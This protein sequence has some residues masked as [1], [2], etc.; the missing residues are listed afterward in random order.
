MKTQNDIRRK[1]ENIKVEISSFFENEII[2]NQRQINK[3][4]NEIDISNFFENEIIRNQRK[5]KKLQ[6]NIDIRKNGYCEICN[7]N[8][9]KFSIAKHLRS[10]KHLENQFIIPINFFNIIENLPS[11]S[12][13]YNPKSLKDLNRDRINLN[14]KDLNK[15]IAKKCLTLITLKIKIYIIL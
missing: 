6:T 9:H 13:K 12:K 1:N 3:L 7:T 5:L 10:I 11:S 15:E 8:V 2:R 4:Q 14:D